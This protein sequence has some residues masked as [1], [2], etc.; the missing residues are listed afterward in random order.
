M[1]ISEIQIVPVKPNNGLVAFASCIVD[2]CLYLG[3]I[4]ILTRL[5]GGYRLTYPTKIVGD[6]QINLFHPISQET[7]K[8][9]EEKIV[10]VYEEVMKKHARHNQTGN[11]AEQIYRY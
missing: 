10:T 6:K 3:S 1:K 7:G 9:I 4:G 5:D 11:T 8:F 2:D